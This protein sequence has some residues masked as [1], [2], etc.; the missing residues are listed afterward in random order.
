MGNVRKD[1]SSDTRH[2]SGVWRRLSSMEAETAPGCVR[3]LRVPHFLAERSKAHVLAGSA[4]NR[5]Q[6]VRRVQGK[7]WE[8]RVGV[9]AGPLRNRASGSFEGF[10]WGGALPPGNQKVTHF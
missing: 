5:I 3:N 2:S 6:K 7:G 8:V 10:R 1:E 4:S 9:Q